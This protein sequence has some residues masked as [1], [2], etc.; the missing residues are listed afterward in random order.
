[1]FI[2]INGA[3]GGAIPDNSEPPGLTARDREDRHDL[4]AFAG[5]DREMRVVLEHFRGG[6]M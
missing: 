4:D 2:K 6:L 5:K 1:M 3:R